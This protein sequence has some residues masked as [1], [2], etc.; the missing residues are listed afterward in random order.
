M[1][2][3][4][5]NP[6][7]LQNSSQSI[8]SSAHFIKHSPI[9][10]FSLI[11]AD[12]ETKQIIP[13]YQLCEADLYYG[14]YMQQS[15]K[16]QV[17]VNNYIPSE[18]I[19]KISEIRITSFLVPEERIMF[20]DYVLSTWCMTSVICKKTLPTPCTRYSFPEVSTDMLADEPFHCDPHLYL[21]DCLYRPRS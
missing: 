7:S 3:P 15:K 21:C 4:P 6:E 8:A 20:F 17:Y 12:T 2:S 9:L 16:E 18:T 1:Q 13:N 19:S 11:A 10:P 5:R 14:L